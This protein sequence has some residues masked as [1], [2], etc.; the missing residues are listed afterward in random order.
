L[1]NDAV[2][3]KRVQNVFRCPCD[4]HHLW[5]LFGVLYRCLQRRPSRCARSRINRRRAF[6]SCQAYSVFFQRH[7]P[8][9]RNG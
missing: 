1:S 6:C 8:I 5:S 4:Q 3:I 7:Y 2:H 9:Y